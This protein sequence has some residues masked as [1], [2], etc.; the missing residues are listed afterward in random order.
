VPYTEQR[1]VNMQEITGGTP[2]GATTVTGTDGSRQPSENEL[3]IARY[4]GRHV[5]EI[6]SKLAG[7]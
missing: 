2:Y 4:Q 6:A 5:A 3:A 1:L 7:R